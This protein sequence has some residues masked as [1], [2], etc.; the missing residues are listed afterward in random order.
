M[1]NIYVKNYYLTFPQ[2]HSLTSESK[3]CN[4]SKLT[5]FAKL[6]SITFK[7]RPFLPITGPMSYKSCLHITAV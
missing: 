1:K 2:M 6:G 5:L 7:I 4:P 3:N